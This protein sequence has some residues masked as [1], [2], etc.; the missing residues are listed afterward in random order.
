MDSI[1]LKNRCIYYYG[2]PAGYVKD[3]KASVDTL[4]DCEELKAW[5]EKRNYEI[6][7]ME[8][9][10]DKLSSGE[11]MAE[12]NEDYKPLKKV[13]IWQLNADSDFSMRFISLEE[14]QKKFGEPAADD[15][16][17]VFDG[18]LDTN[19]LESIYT[20]CNISHP[21]GYNGHSLSMSDVV[22]LY[23]DGSSSFYYVDRFGFKEIDFMEPKLQQEMGM[24]M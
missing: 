3:G 16:K 18:E 19:D 9:I 24:Q 15:Y 21:K 11:K 2:S 23:D 22:E 10:F 6:N 4:F 5:C 1:K 14:F 12:L 13:R 17:A 7:V 20:I 8:G